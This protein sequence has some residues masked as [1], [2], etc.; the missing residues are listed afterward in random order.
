MAVLLT[1]M[2]NL[3]ERPAALQGRIFERLFQQAEIAKFSSN[4]RRAYEQSIYAYRDIKN[5]MDSERKAG[6][7]E[8]IGIGREEGI[9]IGRE[10]GIEIGVKNGVLRV[11]KAMKAKGIPDE[12]IAEMTGL[13]LQDIVKLETEYQKDVR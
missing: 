12:T 5:G 10:E 13:P 6:I 8:G 7:E 4:E 3:L 11:A 2:S 1:N 9:E